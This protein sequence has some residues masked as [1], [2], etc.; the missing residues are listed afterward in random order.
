MNRWKS[1]AAFAAL[2]ALAYISVAE[3]DPKIP[4]QVLHRPSRTPD[5]VV[6]TWS[7]DPATTQS[8]TWRTEVAVKTAMAEIAEAT[9]G[10]EFRKKPMALD[11]ASENVTTDLG[12][13]RYHSAQFT[14]LKPDTMYA[15]RVGDGF[16]WS[17]WNQFRTASNRPAPVE[18]LYVGDAQVDIYSMWSRLIRMGFSDAPKAR[19]IVHAGD[20]I[21]RAGRDAEWGEWHAA[22]GW[23]NRSVVSFPVPGNHE[24]NN[25]VLTPNWR[26]QFT[27]PMNGLTGLEETNYSVDIQGVRMVAMNSNL[28]LA[29]QATWLDELLSRNPQQWNIVAFHH[30]VYSAAKN[31][32][33]KQLRDLLQP[34]FD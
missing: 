22:A 11:A 33:N 10:P 15:Y 20:L 25:K 7:G 21:N 32:D 6:L 12:E 31:R 24:Y 34:V 1:L 3:N 26:P 17:E 28:K 14:N 2:V 5:R 19:F 23:I 4:E 9:D 30:P 13:A 18:F 29:E 27:L 16:N 8:V